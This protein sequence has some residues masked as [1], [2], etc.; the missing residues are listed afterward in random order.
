MFVY[1]NIN[2]FSTYESDVEPVVELMS[3]KEKPKKITIIDSHGHRHSFLAKGGDDQTLDARVSE[4][5]HLFDFFISRDPK[6][7]ERKVFSILL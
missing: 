6:L 4:L 7:S 3:S 1:N 2:S 5:F